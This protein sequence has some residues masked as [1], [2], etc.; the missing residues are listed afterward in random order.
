MNAVITK[1]ETSEGL[2]LGMTGRVLKEAAT[3]ARFQPHGTK[4]SIVVGRDEYVK[5]PVK[6]SHW[7]ETEVDA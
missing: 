5:V 7:T 4:R 2:E 1:R 3:I 6:G